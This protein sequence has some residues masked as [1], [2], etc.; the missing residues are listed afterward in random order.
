MSY[1]LYIV[2]SRT[3]AQ[4]SLLNAT[5]AIDNLSWQNNWDLSRLLLLNIDKLLEKRALKI[6]DIT[7][8][9]FKNEEDTGFTTSRIGE[10]T[11]KTL[12]FAN[13][14]CKENYTNKL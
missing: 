1:K 7:K 10:I 8:F 3:N 11:T 12:D 14:Y 2:I 4:I 13:R 9:E 5:T 6:S